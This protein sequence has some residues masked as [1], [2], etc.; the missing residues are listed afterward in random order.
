MRRMIL[1]V[2]A[3]CALSVSGTAQQPSGSPAFEVASIKPTADAPRPN[4]RSR[5]QPTSYTASNIPVRE[6][7]KIAYELRVDAQVRGGPDWTNS[8]RFDVQASAASQATPTEIRIML[9][10][11]LADRFKLRA[12]PD[13]QELPVYALVKARSD[14]RLGTAL[15]PIGEK[16]CAP[17][18]T[19][20]TP[21]QLVCGSV[22]FSADSMIVGGVS[23]ARLAELLPGTSGFT[24]I[25]RLVIDR[26]SLSGVYAFEVKYSPPKLPG[27]AQSDS[28]D[29]AAF[30]TALQEQLGLKLEPARAPVEVLVIDSIE[31]PTP[32]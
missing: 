24:G 25:D 14:G 27:L 26:T 16:D 11:V 3:L 7:I 2:A 6:L 13:Q 20:P 19:P 32:D 22:M 12:R 5:F 28:P 18:A 4:W 29:L 17:A 9:R 30:P 21:G 1:T 8:A 15:K 31:Q 10:G 23:M